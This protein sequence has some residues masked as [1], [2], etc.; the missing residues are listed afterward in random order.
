MALINCPECN[1]E[2]SD[3]SEICI[4]CGY[5]LPKPEPMFQGVYC[6]SCLYSR[7]KTKIDTCPYCDIKFKDSINF[8]TLK[9][10]LT[11]ACKPSSNPIS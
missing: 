3:K 5:K 1:K 4:N 6:P 8:L 2:I 10:Q 11:F 9:S 7:I